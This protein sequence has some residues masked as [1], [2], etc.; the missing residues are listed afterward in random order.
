MAQNSYRRDRDRSQ[1]G[2]AWR[3]LADRLAPQ[4]VLDLCK[5]DAGSGLG[6]TPSAGLAN[7]SVVR[8]HPVVPSPF[9]P[10]GSIAAQVIYVT[11]AEHGVKAFA[12]TLIA[13]KASAVID[14]T[15]PDQVVY[16]HGTSG[17][18]PGCDQ[19]V[20]A[21][22][23]ANFIK[24]LRDT[25]ATQLPDML[26]GFLDA[27]KVV[28]A[29]YYVGIGTDW[30][31]RASPYLSRDTS[32][33]T[34][35]DAVRAVASIGASTTWGVIGHSQGG[36][37]AL[38]AADLAPTYGAGLD[39]VGAV[40]MAP[41]LNLEAT[42]DYWYD[43]ITADVTGTDPRPNDGVPPPDLP[44]V[45][46]MA[47]HL[48]WGLPS[49]ASGMPDPSAMF[50]RWFRWDSRQSIRLNALAVNPVGPSLVN[51]GEQPTW[52]PTYN[53]FT[54]GPSALPDS[55]QVAV[56]TP[57]EHDLSAGF[58][59]MDWN[60]NPWSVPKGT[61]VIVGCG[62]PTNAAPGGVLY[63]Y[64]ANYLQNHTGYPAGA[65]QLGLPMIFQGPYTSPTSPVWDSTRAVLR[66]QSLVDHRI[67]GPLLITSGGLDNLVPTGPPGSTEPHTMRASVA[68][69][70]ANGSQV[71]LL[72]DPTGGHGEA[73]SAF[74]DAATQWLNARFD[75]LPINPPDIC[76]NL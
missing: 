5:S 42:F 12:M 3:V 25:D 46:T 38:A 24:P 28:Q 74:I 55:S 44:S 53:V 63:Q 36:Q 58:A 62:W 48:F 56:A 61:R 34:I 71:Q 22:S 43:S 52:N 70:C 32:G 51:S 60:Y 8:V 57:S 40:G 18:N 15:M 49:D 33:R 50:N 41:P 20:D 21:A 4:G 2:S 66:N 65:L 1:L 17:I 9:D 16:A 67:N 11:E 26:E 68:A 45:M 35:I 14:G 7:G 37:A 73:F 76:T 69:M 31:G 59:D 19:A 47:A 10:E 29:P 75:G 6:L 64:V 27:G 13:M 23:A 39:L 30:V 54:Y 72:D